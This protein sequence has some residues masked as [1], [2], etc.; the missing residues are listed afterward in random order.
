M[1]RGIADERMQKA[2]EDP[3][4]AKAAYD[5]LPPGAKKELNKAASDALQKK[6]GELAPGLGDDGSDVS[7]E[8]SSRVIGMAVRGRRTGASASSSGSSSASSSGASASSAGASNILGKFQEL[9][10]EAAGLMGGDGS[11]DAESA[12]RLASEKARS[13][14]F[15]NLMSSAD[16]FKGADGKIDKNKVQAQAM[17]K[18]RGGFGQLGGMMKFGGGDGKVGYEA[19]TSELMSDADLD[20]LGSG[21]VEPD[22]PNQSSD[23]WLA[24]D[25]E[26]DLMGTFD[27]SNH[28]KYL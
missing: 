16:S 11:V 27:A 28:C 2:E 20:G 17:S 14:G 4:G 23:P 19:L 24:I 8:V 12:M 22:V 9:S 5:A 21:T 15:G 3:E 7:S 6:A 1:V 26:A 13:T 25:A 10:P 18:I